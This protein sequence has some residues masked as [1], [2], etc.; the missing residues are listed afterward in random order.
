MAY[1]ISSGLGDAGVSR[2][3]EV[4]PLQAGDG[5]AFHPQEMRPAME[6]DAMG[7]GQGFF[8][9][10]GDVRVGVAQD[11]AA[12]LDHGDFYPEAREMVAGFQTHRA[13]TQDDCGLGKIGQF[14]KVVAGEVAG[15]HQ[16]GDRQSGDVGPGGDQPGADLDAA[17]FADLPP[18]G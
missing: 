18:V 11:V 4:D 10:A 17:A 7:V 3:V 9:S 8:Q 2:P 6:L 13:G 5:I 1:T 16:T 12:P 14:Q 15:F